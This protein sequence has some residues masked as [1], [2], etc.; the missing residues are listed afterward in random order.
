MH[1][2]RVEPPRYASIRTIKLAGTDIRQ[3]KFDPCILRI[4][5][6]L[7]HLGGTIGLL[8]SCVALLFHSSTASLLLTDFS[9]TDSGSVGELMQAKESIKGHSEWV[10]FVRAGD[11]RAKGSV[12]PLSWNFYSC[13]L[14]LRKREKSTNSDVS[15]DSRALFLSE[16]KSILSEEM[17]VWAHSP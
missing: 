13:A 9:V 6:V 5:L 14:S 12:T 3:S 17:D 16:I 7:M 11:P 4:L 15:V 1:F 10:S 2:I 8:E